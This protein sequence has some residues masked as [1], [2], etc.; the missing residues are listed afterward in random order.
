VKGQ[1]VCAGGSADDIHDVVQNWHSIDGSYEGFQTSY[2]GE[3]TAF[4][5]GS[6]SG[7]NN[8]PKTWLSSRQAPVMAFVDTSGDGKA[9]HVILIVG[10]QCCHAQSP[11]E[12]GCG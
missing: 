3:G 7:Y 12:R 11:P 9:N 5:A 2:K 10:C 4:T 6:P 8:D 1:V